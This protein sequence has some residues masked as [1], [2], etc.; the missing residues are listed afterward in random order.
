MMGDFNLPKIDWLTWT[1]P[2]ENMNEHHNLFIE[3]I[4]DNYLYQHINM[5]TRGHIQQ[6]PNI[7]ILDLILSHEEL[8]CQI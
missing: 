5:P 6:Q 2:R 4:R 8:W 1:T 3:C 7:Y